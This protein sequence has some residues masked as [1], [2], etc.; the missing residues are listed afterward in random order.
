ME[1]FDTCPSVKERDA[2]K[3]DI[4]TSPYSFICFIFSIV[5]LVLRRSMYEISYSPTK[6]YPP[7][8]YMLHACLPTLHN[9]HDI[10]LVTT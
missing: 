9:Y 7:I 4:V 5:D 1:G 8:G 10:K 6:V 2:L 3:P